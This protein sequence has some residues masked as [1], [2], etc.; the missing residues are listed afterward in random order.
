MAPEKKILIKSFNSLG[1]ISY[2][3][4]KNIIEA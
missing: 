3:F 4:Q 2:M 1:I